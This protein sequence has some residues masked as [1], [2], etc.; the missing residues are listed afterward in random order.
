M[1]QIE[2]KFVVDGCY[3]FDKEEDA[4]AFSDK[5]NEDFRRL[6]NMGFAAAKEAVDQFPLYFTPYRDGDEIPYEIPITEEDEL[7]DAAIGVMEGIYDEEGSIEKV[8]VIRHAVLHNYRYA[9]LG[10]IVDIATA[11]D[12]SYGAWYDHKD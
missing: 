9:A 1:F 6:E 2:K 10:V 12:T 11:E 8:P 5:M 7:L 3:Q 4:I